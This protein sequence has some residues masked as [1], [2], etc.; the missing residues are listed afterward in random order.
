[1]DRRIEAFIQ[2]KRAELNNANVLEFCNRHISEDPEFSCARV[3]SVLVGRRDDGKSHFRQSQVVN[4]DGPQTRSRPTPPKRVKTEEGSSADAAKDDDDSEIPVGIR[5]RLVELEKKVPSIAPRGP[6]PKD[7][8]ARI[9]ALEDRVM[10]LEGVSPEYFCNFVKKE[11]VTDNGLASAGSTG[12][13]ERS[14]DI[15]KSLSGI[16]SRI[17]KL[18]ASLMVKKRETE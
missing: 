9:K 6:V 14:E 15:A 3:D 18:Q 10:Y 7:V 8:Y 17:Q 16:N 1:M 4:H 13:V 2:R 5:E 12:A 11:S